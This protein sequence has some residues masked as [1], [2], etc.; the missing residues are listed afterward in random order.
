MKNQCLLVLDL[1]FK[2][3]AA[4]TVPPAKPSQARSPAR[5]VASFASKQIFAQ[6]LLSSGSDKFC[7]LTP[8]YASRGYDLEGFLAEAAFMQC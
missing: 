6:V 7:I 8:F 3:S 1:K 4:S 5:Q 2:F